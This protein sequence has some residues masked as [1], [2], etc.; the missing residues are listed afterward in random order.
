MIEN[1]RLGTNTCGHIFHY[2]IDKIGMAFIGGNMKCIKSSLKLICCF[3][4]DMKMKEYLFWTFSPVFL[5]KTRKYWGMAIPCSQTK[6][7]HPIC[8][9]IFRICPIFQQYFYL[10]IFNNEKFTNLNLLTI[11]PWPPLAAICNVVA[12][13]VFVFAWI[14]MDL[15]IIIN[16]R[17]TAKLPFIAAIWAP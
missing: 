10:I 14:T 11:F 17:T 4:I 3:K 12:S 13:N 6:W 8:I 15:S 7:R 16:S 2:F 1:W 5:L 9:L